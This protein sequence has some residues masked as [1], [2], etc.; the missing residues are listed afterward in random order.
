MR[1]GRR[2]RHGEHLVKV[3]LPPW[4]GNKLA[5]CVLL[6]LL[7]LVRRRRWEKSEQIFSIAFFLLILLVY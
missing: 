1:I 6:M 2:Y 4:R 7:L 5:L 3:G